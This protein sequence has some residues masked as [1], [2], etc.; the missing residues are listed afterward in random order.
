MTEIGNALGYIRMVRSAGMHRVAEAIQ[1][2]PDLE[3]IKALSSLLQEIGGDAD[4]EGENGG[5]SSAGDEKKQSGRVDQVVTE[6]AKKFAEGTDYLKVLV[7]VFQGVMLNSPGSKHLENFYMI[8]PALSINFTESSLLAKDNLSKAH[9]GKEAYFTDDGF[10]IG[11]AYVLGIL[12][13]GDALDSLHW[14]ESV[15]QKYTI[16]IKELKAE[17]SQR[18]V[19]LAERRVNA[20]GSFY[21]RLR[22]KQTETLNDAE[23]TAEADL[24]SEEKLRGKRL[25]KSLKEYRMLTFA[26]SGARS[27]LCQEE[28]LD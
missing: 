18:E 25:Q 2:V 24:I 1:F 12:K 21:S 13:Q 3:H 7:D 19:Q 16:E 15:E 28:G 27:F 23:L 14:F 8:V 10:A 11:L 5:P 17:I 26:L 6:L 20:K 9:K 22:S 4:V